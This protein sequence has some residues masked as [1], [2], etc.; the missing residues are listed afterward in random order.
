MSRPLKWG[1]LDAGTII[2]KHFI[3]I[4][5]DIYC[6]DTYYTSFKGLDMR[7]L[8]YEIRIFQKVYNK[9]T[10]TVW[11]YFEIHWIRLCIHASKKNCCRG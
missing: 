2:F 8:Q 3:N 4:F 9:V 6:T 10:I 1:M 5:G 7:N 11:S